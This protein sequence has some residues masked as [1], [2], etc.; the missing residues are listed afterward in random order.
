M[1][2]TPSNKLWLPPAAQ[3]QRRIHAADRMRVLQQQI[4]D[5]E[6]E[7]ETLEKSITEQASNGKYIPRML[8]PLLKTLGLYK[9]IVDPQQASAVTIDAL[10]QAAEAV[11]PMPQAI[12]L[13]TRQLKEHS[14]WS[15]D[16][17]E[18]GINL[19][20]KAI[21]GRPTLRDFSRMDEIKAWWS[22]GGQLTLNPYTG[23]LGAFTADFYQ[24]GWPL[25]Q[26][27]PAVGRDSLI[28]DNGV[29]F[30]NPSRGSTMVPYTAVVP[31]DPALMRKTIPQNYKTATQDDQK[32]DAYEAKLR[33]AEKQVD[34]VMLRPDGTAGTSERN[35]VIAEY[36]EDEVGWLIRTRRTEW[37]AQWYGHSEIE[38]LLG[39]VVGL[40]NAT[41]YNRTF[42]TNN[43][44]PQGVLAATGDWDDI[45]E[46]ALM[47]VVSTLTQQAM[48]VGKMHKLAVFFGGAGQ[49]IKWVPMRPEGQDMAWRMWMIWQL[50]AVA[51]GIGVAAEEINFQAFLSAGGQ[52]SGTGGEERVVMARESS[53]PVLLGDMA[54]WLNNSF[55]SKWY[56]DPQTGEG[57]YE[58]YFTGAKTRDKEAQHQRRIANLGAGLTSI[59]REMDKEDSTP[60]RDPDDP[61]LWDAVMARA[62]E[63]HPEWERDPRYLDQQV[64][65]A[66]RELG[67]KLRRW[68]DM[69]IAPSALQAQM[70]EEQAEQQAQA[71]EQGDMSGMGGPEGFGGRGGGEEPPE[72][73]NGPQRP[74]QGQDG[75]PGEDEE[76]PTGSKWLAKSVAAM[77]RPFKRRGGRVLEVTIG[78]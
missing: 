64:A 11:T 66:Y 52:Q 10:R 58:A 51:A 19:R 24:K 68:T 62:Q 13:R 22:R 20:M 76:L 7:A 18:P 39:E 78:E 5:N 17:N 63:T 73:Q 53:L 70:Q 48:G 27:L 77:G 50:N 59:N 46:E 42:F 41:T 57:P 23:R 67:G 16:P 55:I 8:V 71:A 32:P 54:A 4:A 34:Y 26:L 69:P 12:S 65:K 38:W 61:D 31:L 44:I 21:Y 43:S 28:V 75:A 74:A 14:E 40:L 37:W 45:A 9:G 72:E 47:D 30:A 33:P 60:F 2:T 6:G 49:D 15:I 29:V 1:D 56:A 35:Q 25:R 3:E 36:T